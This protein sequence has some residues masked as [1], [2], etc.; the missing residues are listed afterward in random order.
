MTTVDKV[1][2]PLLL[3][4]LVF[5]AFSYNLSDFIGV[6]IKNI[7]FRT[8]LRIYLHNVHMRIQNIILSFVCRETKNFVLCF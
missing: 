3:Q 1:S 6:K 7:I 5:L 4:D 8:T 2:E